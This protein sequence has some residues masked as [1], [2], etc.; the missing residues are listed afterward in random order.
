MA[1]YNKYKRYYDNKGR[2]KKINA[3]NKTDAYKS[4]KKVK[5]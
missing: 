4:G 2:R 1:G 5:S 3:K